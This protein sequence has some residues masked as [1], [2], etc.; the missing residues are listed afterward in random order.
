MLPAYVRN[1]QFSAL[2]GNPDVLD[3]LLGGIPTH[4]SVWDAR[5]DPARFTLR[6]MLAHIAD[7][8]PIFLDRLKRTVE[9]DEPMLQGYDEGQIAIER[10]YAHSDPLANLKRFREGRETLL[11]FLQG[12]PDG[13]W[14]RVGRHTEIGPISL[15]GLLSLVVG[16]DG[17]HTA[18]VVQW[19]TASEN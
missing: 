19:L 14:D 5:P 15:E 12:L 8:E 1:Y 10:D 2:R 17:Y 9:Q 4:S 18:Q 13:V 3:R 11:V 6:E 7:W 16:H